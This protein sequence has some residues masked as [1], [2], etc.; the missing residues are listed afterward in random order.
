M[1]WIMSTTYTPPPS[2]NGNRSTVVFH[3]NS[4]ASA[5]CQGGS[6]HIVTIAG[7]ASSRI[8]FPKVSF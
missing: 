4:H 2:R 1:A 6:F 5:I 3:Y 7:R 8:M